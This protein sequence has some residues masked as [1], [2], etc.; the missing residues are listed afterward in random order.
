MIYL[1]NEQL[2]VVDEVVTAI[3]AEEAVLATISFNSQ[4]FRTLLKK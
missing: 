3:V 1:K 4:E 2:D